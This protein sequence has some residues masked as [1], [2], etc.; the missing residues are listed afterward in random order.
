MLMFCMA[1]GFAACSDDDENTDDPTLPEEPEVPVAEPLS[2]ELEASYEIPMCQVLQIVPK[3]TGDGEYTYEWKE[4]ETVISSRDTLEFIRPEAK[5]YRLTLT[6]NS[7]TEADTVECD[8]VVTEAAITYKRMMVEYKPAYGWKEF[9]LP[10][11]EA[12][13]LYEGRHGEYQDFTLG[14]TGGYAVLKLDHTIA[15]MPDSLDFEAAMKYNITPTSCDL[16]YIVYVAYDRNKNGVPDEDEWYEIKGSQYG[17]DNEI[18]DYEITY[19]ADIVSGTD[20]WYSEKEDMYLFNGYW[21][22]NQGNSG[23]DYLWSSNNSEGDFINVIPGAY[24]DGTGFYDGWDTFPYVRKGKV[25]KSIP[26]DKAG[27]IFIGANDRKDAILRVDI[28]WAVDKDGNPALL[29]GVDFVKIQNATPKIEEQDL[30]GINTYMISAFAYP[31]ITD[32]TV[33]I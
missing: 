2:V 26:E 33:E 23:K 22:D 29:P 3:V 11:E 18:A 17:T 10:Y 6:V 9:R 8:V 14:T 28:D 19:D 12:L 4:G 13:K 7:E 16:V 15:N 32:I 20:E 27:Y 5:T 24:E 30:W 1:V 25:L 21:K 31:Q